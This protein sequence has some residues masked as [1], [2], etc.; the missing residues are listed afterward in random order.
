MLAVFFIL[1][2]F[3]FVGKKGHKGID[4]SHHQGKIQWEHVASE[5]VEFVYI[6]ATE[7]VNYVDKLYKHNLSEAKKQGILVGSYHFFR[8]DKSGKEQFEHFKSI[9][10]SDFDLIPVLDLEELGGKISDKAKY[11]NEVLAFVECFES[12]YGYKPY[13]YGSYSFMKDFVYPVAEECDYWLAWYSPLAKAIK[14]KR[15]FL[16]KVRPGLH[17]RMWQYSDKGKIKGITGDV[18]LDEC[19]EIEDI[20]VKKNNVQ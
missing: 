19:W 17:A 7:G 10:G 13:V 16:N 8:A 20:K 3:L 11:K 6:K 15:R 9:I 18:D 5:Q 4:I 2:V 1:I 12:F 14:D